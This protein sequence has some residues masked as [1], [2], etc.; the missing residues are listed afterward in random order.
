MPCADYPGTKP[1]VLGNL[2]LYAV[3]RKAGFPAQAALVATSVALEES[4]GGDANAF[5][6]NASTGDYSLGLF[7]INL[8]GS[9]RADRVKRWNI[10]DEK[11][12]LDPLFNAQCAYS[13]WHSAGGFRDW[14]TFTSG[15]YAKN[16]PIAQAAANSVTTAGELNSLVGSA[17][18]N[19]QPHPSAPVPGDSENIGTLF[20]EAG[21]ALVPGLSKDQVRAA[22]AFGGSVYSTAADSLSFLKQLGELGVSRLL[23]LAFALILGGFGF[24]LL[25][26]KQIDNAGKA[27]LL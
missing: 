24:Y 22:G 13:L 7:Q 4:C 16:L 17:E 5:N 10:T 27:A 2:E 26:H 12:L 1:N 15:T 25:F 18:I 3:C 21:A 23:K 19:H 11:Q 9:L 8:Y 20:G 14:T 6:D